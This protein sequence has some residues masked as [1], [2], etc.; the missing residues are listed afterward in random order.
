[1]QLGASRIACAVCAPFQDFL[2]LRHEGARKCTLVHIG[3]NIAENVQFGA[4]PFS[5]QRRDDPKTQRRRDFRVTAIDAVFA[6]CGRDWSG[7]VGINRDWSRLEVENAAQALRKGR[8]LWA[9]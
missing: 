5:T 6:F 7:L 3:A 2:V 8:G 9:R 4:V 1:M